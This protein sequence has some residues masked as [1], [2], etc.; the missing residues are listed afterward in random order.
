[1]RFYLPLF[2]L[3][4]L[5]TFQAT[6]QIKDTIHGTIRVKKKEVKL[7]ASIAGKSGGKISPLELCSNPILLNDKSKVISFTIAFSLNGKLYEVAFKDII[8]G[9]YCSMIYSL[10]NGSKL[11]VE[12]IRAVGKNHHGA[13]VEIPSLAFIIDGASQQNGTVIQEVAVPAPDLLQKIK[14][15]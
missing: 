5:I 14:N 11:Y 10:K 3:L 7:V 6:G 12:N 4:H 13:I 9:D 1:M 8:K 15:Q 2:I